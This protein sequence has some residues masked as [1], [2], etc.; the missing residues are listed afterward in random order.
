MFRSVRKLVWLV[1]LISG[2]VRLDVALGAEEP[3]LPPAAKTR[4]SFQRD[5]QP[6]LESRC[7]LCH[8]PNQQMNGLRLDHRE[9]ALRGSDSGAVIVPGNSAQ[10]RLIHMVAGVEKDRF[11][12]P[13]GER[14][15][16]KEIGKLRAWI[17]QGAEW[18]G[19]ETAAADDPSTTLK[20]G[21]WAFQPLRRP[22]L[23]AVR[24]PGSIRNPI[25]T[26]VLA[27]LEAEGIEPSPQADRATLLRRVSLDLTG[28]PPSPKEMAEFLADDRADAYE[29]LVDRLL[30]SDHYGEKWARHWLDQARYADSDGY[31]KDNP[32]PH[33]WRYRHWVINALNRDMP[34]DQFTI[35]QLAGDL[36]PNATVEQKVATG[37]HRNTLKNIEGGVNVEQYRFEEVVDRTATTGT[38]WLGLTLGCARCHDH[39]YDPIS[40]KDFYRFLAFFNNAGELNIDAPL[41]GELGPYFRAF[42]AFER[43]KKELLREYK[44]PELQPSWEARVKAAGANPGKWPPWDLTYD[45]MLLWLG[46]GDNGQ[47]ILHTAPAQRTP[48]ESYLLSNFFIQNYHRV[49]SDE[50][51]EETKFKDLR[52]KLDA[53][54]ESFPALSK[55]QTVARNPD[56]RETHVHIRGQWDRKGIEVESGTPVFL[57]ASGLPEKATRLDLARWLVS[58]ENRLTPRVT[59]NRIWQEHFGRG[60]VATSDNF[61][62]QGEQPSHPI[63]LDWLASEFIARGWSLKRMHQLIVTSATYRQSS[64]VRPD[65]SSR[66]PNNILLARQSRVRLPAEL[67]R[68]SAL[69]ASGLLNREVG[70]KS[71]RPPLPE[72]LAKLGFASGIKWKDS[73]GPDLYRRSLYIHYQRTVPYPLLANFDA[74]EANVTACRRERSNT[75]LQAL[76]LL[77]D[78]VFFE[79]SQVLAARVLWEAPGEDFNDRLDHAFRLCLIR[80]PTATEQERL[81]RY[82]VKQKQL[83]E[84]DPEASKAL[85]PAGLDDID[86]MEGAA[87]VGVS[88]ILLNLDEF[89]T[90]E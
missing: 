82:F 29:R 72:G 20:S 89:I 4:V 10:S 11:M 14:L 15:S 73:E 31:E 56:P 23:P 51:F 5:V 19:S 27:R 7:Y 65:I 3:K 43:K 37:F 74:P 12:P 63:L 68:D 2:L 16:A 28:L 60:L 69:A 53:L 62:T 70:G 75:P 25:D 38:V 42:P 54:E 46:P 81:L 88:R 45:F 32:R 33:A 36:L 61:G 41:A 24:N 21:H 64:D 58:P 9:D 87:W 55:A 34:F 52:K 59:V 49:L 86:R 13:V 8:G 47:P 84:K 6:L 57:P 1:G 17:D 18:T 35:E 90:R 26:F 39:K 80:Q 79:A 50:E 40:Q 83:Q 78:P 77:N 30:E 44:V 71:V 48:R 22:A 85:F 67:I 66:D 76:D